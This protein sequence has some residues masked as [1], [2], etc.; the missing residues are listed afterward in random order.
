MAEPVK[1]LETPEQ[2]RLFHD[3]LDANYPSRKEFVPPGDPPSSLKKA[4]EEFVPQWLEASKKYV[5]AKVVDWMR[6][7]NLFKNVLPT[8]FWNKPAEELEQHLRTIAEGKPEGSREK[9]DWQSHWCMAISHIVLAYADNAYRAIF[10]SDQWLRVRPEE[11]VDPDALQEQPGEPPKENKE[12]KDFSTAEKMEV[13][14]TRS[15][16]KS[17]IRNAV[18]KTLIFQML[19]GTI[20]GQ[21]RWDEKTVEREYLKTWYDP[22]TGEEVYTDIVKEQ[23]ELWGRPK[24]DMIRPD[25]ILPDPQANDLDI[26]AWTGIGHRMDVP[27]YEI[28]RGYR[29]GRFNLNK[30]EFME[31][32]PTDSFDN[33][34]EQ[35]SDIGVDRDAQSADQE[36]PKKLQLWQYHGLVPDDDGDKEVVCYIVTEV[37]THPTPENGIMIGLR[38][39]TLLECGLRPYVCSQ[40][41]PWPAPMGQSGIEPNLDG[42]WIVSQLTNMAIDNLRITTNAMLKVRKGTAV[43]RE[44]KTGEQGNV[45]TPGRV[46]SCDDPN[47][48]EALQQPQIDFNALRAQTQFHMYDLQNRL[49]TGQPTSILTGG[50]KTASEIHKLSQQEST[51]VAN[52]LD[53]FKEDFLDPFLTLALALLQQFTLRDKSIPIKDSKGIEQYVV[54]TADEIRTGKYTVEATLSR[55]DQMSLAE[56]QTLERAFATLLQIKMALEAEDE[57][58]ALTPLVRNWLKKLRVEPLDETLRPMTPQEKALRQQ[59]MAMQGMGPPEAPASGPGS[60][61]PQAQIPQ[62]PGGPM[63]PVPNNENWMM[64]L[65]QQTASDMEGR[66]SQL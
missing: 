53:L 57:V 58:L 28:V 9:D 1:K 50:E 59:M 12:D 44:L 48:L 6:L 29:D 22:A 62:P 4:A 26:Q 45:W 34:V 5:D 21:A 39:G 17:H 33:S 63:G 25:Q 41:T 37:G 60:G 54:L 16:A 61:G 7:E 49:N 42:V 32:W 13:G 14:V 23:T 55:P 40:F 36:T 11:L 8:D 38:A 51:P 64:Q 43:E 20:Y 47:D 3:E 27:R 46:L 31:K 65:L 56:A 66:T 2:I 10:A 35:S 52:R 15:L 30:S 19:F 18:Y 24:L